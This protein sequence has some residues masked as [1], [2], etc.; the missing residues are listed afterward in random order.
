MEN[1]AAK[2]YLARV[3][4]ALVCDKTDRCRLLE[5]CAAMIDSFQQESPEA[6][7]DGLVAAF[8]EPDAF[9]AELLSGLDEA[10][11]KTARKRQRL[12]RWGAVA[13]IIAVLVTL[14]AFLYIKYRQ[15][16]E[17]GQY[18]YAVEGVPQEMPP[19]EVE[20]I[21]DQLPEK[22]HSYGAK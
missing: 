5:R 10:A 21:M 11:V 18:F 2:Q 12:I 8:G 17:I 14:L 15:S 16:M 9:V 20:A 13:A 4:R 3:K 22:S 19:D 1:K 7:Y 6:G